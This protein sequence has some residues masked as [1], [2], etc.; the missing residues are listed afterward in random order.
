VAQRALGLALSGVVGWC[1]LPRWPSGSW[2][3]FAG[4]TQ[5]AA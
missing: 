4:A 5:S 3:P 1:D 2:R